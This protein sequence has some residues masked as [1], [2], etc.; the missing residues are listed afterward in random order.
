MSA[1]LA[2]GT[3]HLKGIF[4][5]AQFEGAAHHGRETRQQEKEAAGH[6]HPKLGSKVRHAGTQLPL[7]FIQS[8]TPAWSVGLP[9]FT[10]CLPT[11][12]K[13]VQTCPEVFL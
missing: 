5:S 3:R 4:V 11:S 8:G 9:T 7:L 6:L 10:V 2:A 12:V 1:L 13:P